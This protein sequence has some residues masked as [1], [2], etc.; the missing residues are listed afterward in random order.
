MSKKTKYELPEDEEVLIDGVKVL[1]FG[2]ENIKVANIA[3]EAEN[4]IKLFGANK[5]VFRAIVNL[6]SGLKPGAQRFLWAWWL[7]DKK[8]Q[9][10]DNDTINNLKYHKAAILTTRTME[11]HPHSDS[12][13]SSML[14][15]LGQ[16]FSNNVMLI[17]P[18]GSYGNLQ[19]SDAGAA[20]YIEAKLSKFTIDCF[21]EDFYKY[22][23]PMKKN[24]LGEE[25]E[26]ICLYSKYPVYYSIPSF[27]LW[28]L[29]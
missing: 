10:I 29:V 3:S 28:G 24:Y 23:I 16:E 11:F 1:K 8:P 2:N 18:Q 26:P 9:N 13:I 27:H 4:Y 20:R 22:C 12:G 21:F 5:N 6:Q 7:L 25:D 17:V 14:G 15:T 19:F